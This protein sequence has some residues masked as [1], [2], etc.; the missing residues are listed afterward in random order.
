MKP[1]AAAVPIQIAYQHEH[2]WK[3]MSDSYANGYARDVKARPS[4]RPDAVDIVA[5]DTRVA[6]RPGYR[7]LHARNASPL[8]AEWEP[9]GDTPPPPPPGP[10]LPDLPE[11]PARPESPEELPGDAP[12]EVPEQTPPE[13]HG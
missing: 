6:S 7:D 11:D 3:P 13:G 10:E 5:A 1:A 4:G 12:P 8:S 9:P 2:A